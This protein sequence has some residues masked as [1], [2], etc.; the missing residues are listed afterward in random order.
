MS[1]EKTNS[2]MMERA[3]SI[4]K[5][6]GTDSQ[7][8]LSFNE[9]NTYFF[10]QESYG[11]IS[12]LL[13]GKKA[14]SL[15]DP[16]CKSEDTE[17]F[18]SEYI[19]FCRKMGWKPIFNSVSSNI[20]G[21][22]EKLGFSVIKY[23]EEA[24]LELSEYTL[25]GNR[26]AVLRRNVSKVDRSGITLQEYQ[27]ENGRD[28]VLEEKIADLSEKWFAHKKFHLRYTVGGLYFDKPYGRRYFITGD[29][30]GNL[31]TVLSFLPY[32]GG[33][34]FCIDVMYRNLDA[35]RG[36][37]DHAIIASAMKLKAEGVNKIS[38]GIAPLAGIDI[39]KPG[40]SRA[41]RLLN[42]IFN[43]MNSDYNFKNLYRYKKKFDPSKWEPR[44]L[45]YHKGISLVDLA[46]SITHTKR[47]SADLILY[48][49]YKFLLI[50]FNLLPRLN[51][52]EK[53]K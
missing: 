34:S 13:V 8:Y 38:L 4:I 6:C 3:Y 21:I 17:M 31:S 19:D 43:T 42:A 24:I 1:G 45:V 44:Y 10:G 16:V 26:R 29:A 50:I 46:I 9:E 49:K 22:L 27:P 23:G 41:E 39:T 18:I 48:A 53:N 52:I 36:A 15:G 37:M 28:Y 30:K 2:E 11:M 51:K 33:K 7:H 40:V 14:L 47:G 32:D 20:F 35:V 25:A 5:E 12:Y